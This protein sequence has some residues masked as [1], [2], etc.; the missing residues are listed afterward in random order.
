MAPP[1]SDSDTSGGHAGVD[2]AAYGW[3]ADRSEEAPLPE[4]GRFGRLLR[5]ER[6]ECDATT[7]RGS[8]RVV[9][10]SLRAQGDL[11]PVTGDWVVVVDDAD[12]G[13]A[14]ESILPRRHT[15]KRRDPSEQIIE[16]VL[17]ANIDIVMIVQGLDRP[18]RPGRLERFLVLAWNSGADA[19]V[20]LTKSDLVEAEVVAE[21]LATVAAIAADVPALVSSA[22][23]GEGLDEVLARVPSGATGVLVGE[24]G[25]GKSTI[26]NAL[27]GD[28]VQ[29][30]GEVRD[31]DAAGRHTTITRDLLRLPHGGLIIDTPG[32][33]AVGLWDAEDALHQVFGDIVELVG[34]C[35][36]NDCQHGQE[37]GCAVMAAVAAGDLDQ[38]RLDRYRAMYDEL[39]EQAQRQ[40]E[41]E[42]KEANNPGRRGGGKKG[43]G[44]KG[45]GRKGGGKKG[46]GRRR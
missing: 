34:A 21:A 36:F 5:V 18:L 12:V 42:R 17:V 26:I 11:A 44:G 8:E 1:T 31:A 24:S 37:P 16:Q 4:G 13:P 38:R 14:I 30:T 43:A 25:A 35:R 27:M 9:S 15:L 23:T 32:V 40:E 29:E 7:E 46:G 45:G 41:R 3:T 22:S 28:E 6:G 10:D 2:L 19:A 39:V 20:L 33:R